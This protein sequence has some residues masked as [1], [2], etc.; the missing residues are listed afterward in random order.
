MWCWEITVSNALVEYYQR[1]L[2]L[3]KAQKAAFLR[4][5]WSEMLLLGSRRQDLMATISSLTPDNLPAEERERIAAS[6]REIIRGDQELIE[7]L[8]ASQGE[9]GQE[10]AN[11]DQLIEAWR[12]YGR[13]ADLHRLLPGG[14]VDRKMG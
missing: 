4:R 1:L 9:L 5:D 7:L 12:N 2:E 6:I 14:I 11:L 13:N 10:I 3:A 8:R